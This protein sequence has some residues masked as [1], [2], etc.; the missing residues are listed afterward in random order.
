MT[1]K[2]KKSYR[3][4]EG[5]V[6]N[7]ISTDSLFERDRKRR[8]INHNRSES[9]SSDTDCPVPR[10]AMTGKKNKSARRTEGSESNSDSTDNVFQRDEKH[11]KIRHNR[12]ESSSS[13]TDRQVTRPA[14]TG[15]RKKSARRTEGSES[16][17]DNTDNLFQRDR[18][19]RKISHNRSESS[20]SDTERPQHSPTAEVQR[21][22]DTDDKSY[23]LQP[24]RGDEY[25]SSDEGQ[26]VTGHALVLYPCNER[27]KNYSENLLKTE[28]ESEK[29]AT[30]SESGALPTTKDRDTEAAL[31]L[32]T[33]S[34]ATADMSDDNNNE[35]L[36]ESPICIICI[37]E[38]IIKQVGITD[39]C[40]HKF[41]ASCL[42]EWST[43]T[44]TC[45]IDRLTFNFIKVQHH[46][47]GEIVNS[48]PVKPTDQ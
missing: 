19:R 24:S 28:M 43:H 27:N 30:V 23:E 41:C 16:N 37:E 7:S 11:R 31:S 9:S 32:S 1:G 40:G 35:H 46:L 17:R 45:P 38:F 34:R 3:R 8:K 47:N 15:K 22:V 39:T 44:N 18:K 14:M 25:G 21:T 2:R 48:I 29:V 12:F 6:S 13:D 26:K 10:P 20:S 36:T 5:S 4:T 42:Q 33:S